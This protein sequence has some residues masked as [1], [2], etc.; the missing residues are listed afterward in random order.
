MTQCCRAFSDTFTLHFETCS[1]VSSQTDTAKNI[2]RN[3][4]DF[5]D[6]FGFVPNG[7]RQYYTNRSQPPFL[8]L[9]VA[10]LADADPLRPTA[11]DASASAATAVDTAFLIEALPRLETEYAFWTRTGSTHAVSLARTDGSGRVD[12]LCRYAVGSTSPRPESFKEDAELAT[13]RNPS[14]AA[15]VF[16][17][18][19]A[20]GAETGW[21]YS[22]RW[23]ANGLN[24]TT[25]DTMSVIPVDL[26]SIL[27]RVE[28][29][30]AHIHS[31]LPNPDW[32]RVK[33][34]QNVRDS[35]HGKMCILALFLPCIS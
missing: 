11:S 14:I 5:V 33:F 10:A 12:S 34:F 26:N 23:F 3:M 7:G 32:S 20:A 6:R 21:D 16:F 2:L 1:F 27:C 35:V 29:T 28:L 4:L 31:L 17:S 13:H 25:I 15:P 9:M 22:S 19:L 24:E 18:N 8:T 30:M